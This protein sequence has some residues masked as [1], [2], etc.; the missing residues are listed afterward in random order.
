VRLGFWTQ[1]K[2]RAEASACRAWVNKT[3]QRL[4]QLKRKYDPGNFSIRMQTSCPPTLAGNR[5]EAIQPPVN[6]GYWKPAKLRMQG[7]SRIQKPDAYWP[8]RIQENWLVPA[9]QKA[10]IGRISHST[11]LHALG[12]DLKVQQK[13]LRDLATA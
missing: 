2:E 7:F 11:L 12:V 13:S 10:G 9:A 8:S 5:W 6:C 1:W 3:F 4:R